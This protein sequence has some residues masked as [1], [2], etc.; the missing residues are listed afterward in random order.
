MKHGLD[1]KQIKIVGKSC[2]I[3]SKE[4]CIR[5][6]CYQIV[7]QSYYDKIVLL[8]ITISTILLTWDNPNL[9]E[10]GDTAKALSICDIVL[11][12][13]FTLECMINII[14][15]GFICN[16]KKSYARD[17]WNVMDLIIVFFSIFTLIL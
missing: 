7:K 3:F 15:F 16:G 13:V 2:F 8:F 6:L 11:T 12:S 17:P 10:N 4:N 5:R 14:L 1:E 9:D